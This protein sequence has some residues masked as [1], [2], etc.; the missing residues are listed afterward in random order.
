[1]G[2]LLALVGILYFFVCPKKYQKKA[3]G[4]YYPHFPGSSLIKLLYYCNVNSS[5]S[6]IIPALV[7]QATNN[8]GL[9]FLSFALIKL[10]HYCNFN[11]S[12]SFIIPALVCQATNNGG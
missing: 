11:N 9:A 12:F 5:F 7:G 6:F 10:L 1:V 4:K 8:G 2:T 3:P